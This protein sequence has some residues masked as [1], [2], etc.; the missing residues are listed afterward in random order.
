MCQDFYTTSQR[1]SFTNTGGLLQLIPK[2]A[3]EYG[4]TNALDPADNVQGAIRFLKWLQQYWA[5]R[6]VDENERLKFILASY[7]AGVGHVEDAQRMTEKYGRFYPL[8][9]RR[10]S[11]WPLVK[12][13]NFTA[14]L[15]RATES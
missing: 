13:G 11:Q 6:I 14:I 10:R 12:S 8:M 9:S 15:P 1:L 7:N 3:K 4:V 5:K 2:T